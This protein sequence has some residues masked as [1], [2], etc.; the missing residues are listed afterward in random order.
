MSVVVI[1]VS[2]LLTKLI[3]FGEGRVLCVVLEL[4]AAV[5][6]LFV[7]AAP[8]LRSNAVAGLRALEL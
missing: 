5:L 4:R 1:R 8:V 3:A 7:R 2:P 6:A